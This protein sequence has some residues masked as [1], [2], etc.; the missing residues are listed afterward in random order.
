MNA[1][2]LDLLRQWA[3]GE[4]DNDP[5]EVA[6][7]RAQRD[8]ILAAH[9]RH[10]L[11]PPPAGGV[12]VVLCQND[13]PHPRYGVDPDGALIQETYVQH[14][15]LD[16]ARERAAAMERWGACRIGRVVFEDEEGR[17]L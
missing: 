17:P 8:A 14:A 6:N 15:T 3:A 5:Q 12:Y 9:A 2:L 7:A 4:R 13:R 16:K 10:P 11:T 1:A